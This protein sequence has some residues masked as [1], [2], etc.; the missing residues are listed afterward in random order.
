MPILSPYLGFT[1]KAQALQR[2]Q[3]ITSILFRTAMGSEA[4]MTVTMG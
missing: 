4:R 1:R 2:F 3:I